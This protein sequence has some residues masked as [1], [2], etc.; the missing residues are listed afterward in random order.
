MKIREK[1]HV[2]Q[3]K[4]RFNNESL[5]D[6]LPDE[7]LM[8]MKHL[9]GLKYGNLPDYGLLKGLLMRV[10]ENNGYRMDDLYDWQ[11]K[12]NNSTGGGGG[13][14]SSS[15][16]NPQSSTKSTAHVSRSV[17]QSSSA[18]DADG[19]FYDI[20]P[21]P[22]DRRQSTKNSARGG[23]GSGS[24][25]VNNNGGVGGDGVNPSNKSSNAK[26]KGCR[27]TVQ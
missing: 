15:I 27:C 3:L 6:G 21:A 14:G 23:G 20:V 24:G 1:A 8:F 22:A 26:K 18:Q 25:G 12:S 16:K 4:K 17:P 11:K 7:F 13:S 2:L 10:C 9:Q 19:N 5:V